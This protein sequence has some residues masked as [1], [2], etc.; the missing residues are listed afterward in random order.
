MRT[1]FKWVPWAILAA[2]FASTLW[3]IAVVLF[4]YGL[5]VG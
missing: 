5:V 2:A 4:I 3:L 1:F